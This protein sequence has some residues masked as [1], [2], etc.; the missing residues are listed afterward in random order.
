MQLRFSILLIL[1]FFLTIWSYTSLADEET[2]YPDLKPLPSDKRADLE[3]PDELWIRACGHV[4]YVNKPLGYSADEMSHFPSH[5]YKLRVVENLFGDVKEVPRY[6]GYLSDTILE[7][8]DNPAVVALHCFKTLDAYAGRDL[9]AP[10]DDDWGVDWI[11]KGTSPA[12]ALEYVLKSGSNGYD[13]NREI[14]TD[15]SAWKSLPENIQRFVVRAIVASIVATPY[16]KRSFDED[17]LKQY[18][19][20]SDLTSVSRKDLYEFV[21]SPWRED[22]KDA[23]RDSFDALSHIDLNFLAYGTI[24]YLTYIHDALTE[25]GELKNPDLKNFQSFSFETA[26][27]RVLIDGQG[28]LE[29]AG[30]YSLIIN[31]SGNNKYINSKISSNP[32]VNPINS[33]IDFNGS[34]TYDDNNEPSTLVCGL[35][36]LSTIFDLAGDDSYLC[37]SSGIACGWYGSGVVIDYNGNDKYYTKAEWGQGAAHAG[38]GILI[39]HAGNDK[40]Y[41]GSEAQGLGATLGVGLLMDIAGN[42]E[43]LL[44]EEIK[45]K[46]WTDEPPASL[47][48]GCGFGRRADFTDGHSLAGGIGILIEGSGN[49][50]YEGYGRFAQG[51]GYWWGLGLL[52]DYAGNDFYRGYWY[53]QGASAHFAIGCMVDLKGNDTYNDDWTV[54]QVLGNGRD[55]SIAVFIDGDGDD[56]YKVPNRSGGEGDLN[57]IGL[58]WDRR[59]N[60]K[61]TV[62]F[63]E[64]FGTTP[65]L[66]AATTESMQ[67]RTFRDAMPSV[68]LFLDTGGTDIYDGSKYVDAYDKTRPFQPLDNRDWWN[69]IG[70]V[71]WGYGLDIEW[72][73]KLGHSALYPFSLNDAD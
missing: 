37:S 36:G 13:E 29:I 70:P 55:G 18:F 68:G 28:D 26:I 62:Q 61:Y 31:F 56:D 11:P 24:L 12:K 7:N 33:I 15:L 45:A 42:D 63:K 8:R 53:S 49:D 32:F 4:G 17:F 47:S 43:Y 10:K 66:G 58:F 39:D 27:G 6:S 51:T 1:L 41:Y 54:S 30:N 23:P 69:N 50:R 19:K 40:Y 57:G 48:Q 71:L 64:K 59:G 67:Y 25:L 2:D 9:P 52:E 14:K 21:S 60:D 5:P 46:P 3:I 44:S 38:A 65:V 35:F 20:T 16:I 34:D 73:Q 22:I 72:Y